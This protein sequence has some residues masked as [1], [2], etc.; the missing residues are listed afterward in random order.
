MINLI[1][2]QHFYETGNIQTSALWIS[3]TPFV[4]VFNPAIS[5]F[6]EIRNYSIFK[7]CNG[8]TTR[9]RKFKDLIIPLLSMRL[10][11]FF[12]IVSFSNLK[13][14]LPYGYSNRI[15]QN[16]LFCLTHFL[17]PSFLFLCSSISHRTLANGYK[18]GVEI[19]SAL[20]CIQVL[21]Y[22]RVSRNLVGINFRHPNVMPNFA[23]WKTI[24]YR[25]WHRWCCQPRF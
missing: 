14:I 7:I 18:K 5:F 19:V 12:K 23:V 2:I 6:F 11:S 10:C 21:A 17:F 8:I 22:L 3:S 1:N 15:L 24:T 4:F 25:H 16:Q 20:S 9:N 13:N